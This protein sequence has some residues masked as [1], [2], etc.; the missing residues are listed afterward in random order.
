MYLLLDR[1][2]SGNHGG[3]FKNTRIKSSGGQCVACHWKRSLASR[4][5]SKTHFL[6]RCVSSST[7][8]GHDASC[9]VTLA[10]RVSADDQMRLWNDTPR[11]HCYV[12]IIVRMYGYILLL[13]SSSSRSCSC[14]CCCLQFWDAGRVSA[15]E[16]LRGFN[17]YC[18]F[19]RPTRLDVFLSSRQSCR[20]AN[21]MHRFW[22]PI[23]RF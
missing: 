20:R 17:I 19:V 3:D 10:K 21:S 22:Y 1:T 23:G 9:E 2:L 14:C 13:L 18:Q 11:L 6:V 12:W 7:T 15:S 8:H 16:S 4:I 5:N